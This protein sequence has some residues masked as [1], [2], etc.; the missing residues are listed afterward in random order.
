[1]EHLNKFTKIIG[2]IFFYG[3]TLLGS[4]FYIKALLKFLMR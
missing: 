1:M 2:V 3:W 4:I